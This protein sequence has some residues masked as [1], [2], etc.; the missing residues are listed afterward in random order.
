LENAQAKAAVYVA[1]YTV[2]KVR[3]PRR[4]AWA[5][6]TIKLRDGRKSRMSIGETPWGLSISPTA[7][8][9]NVAQFL[10][11]ARATP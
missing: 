11:L 1:S 3:R 7:A 5:I 4:K 2:T 8:G 6:V 10:K 9:K